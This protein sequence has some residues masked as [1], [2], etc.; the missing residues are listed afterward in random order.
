MQRVLGVQKKGPS[1]M[2]RTGTTLL[3]LF[4]SGVV[5]I[6]FG[7]LSATNTARKNA[8]KVAAPAPAGERVAAPAAL[9]ASAGRATVTSTEFKFSA[10]AIDAPAGKLRLTLDNSG[11]I[12]HELVL[13]KTSAAPGSLKVAANGRV[14][15]AASVGEVSEIKSGVSKSTTFDLKPGRYV[16]VCN[17]P[18]HYG[19]GMRGALVVK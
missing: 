15:E 17:I 9:D 4:M 1:P 8:E 2:L 10:S 5:L 11:K 3:A 7:G 19:Q 18:G 13:L 12:E 14:S 6:V 16:Y